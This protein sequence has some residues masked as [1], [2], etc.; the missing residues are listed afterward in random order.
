MIEG[1][2]NNAARTGHTPPTEPADQKR[3]D[4]LRVIVLATI[5]AVIGAYLIASSILI[6]KDGVFYI[7]QAQQVGHDLLGVAKRYPPAYPLSLFAAH[8]VARWFVGNDSTALWVLSSQITTLLLR[9]LALIVLFLAG[10]RLVGSRRSFHAVVIL[11]VLP[12]AAHDGSDVLREW[13]VLL[14]IAGGLWLLLW[15]VQQQRWH[16]FGWVGLLA[17]VGYSLHPTCVQLVLYGFLGL[18]LLGPRGAGGR[19]RLAGAGLVSALGFALAVAPLMVAT[20]QIAPQQ[21]Q[22]QASTTR[23]PVIV[24]VA[25]QPASNDPIQVNIDENQTAELAVEVLDPE[26]KGLKLE[27][28]L[29]PVGTRPV[30]SF[31]C[32]ANDACLLTISEREKNSVLVDGSKGVWAYEGIGCYAYPGAKD[33]PGLRPVY[34]LWSPVLGR[35]FYTA[36][37]PE[38]NLLLNSPSSGQWK[39]E[40]IAFYV[41]A[42]AK[43]SPQTVPIH[44]FQISK[45]EHFW[46]VE[47]LPPQH[48]KSEM[49]Y[50][51]IAWY[52]LSGH[53]LPT[54]ASFSE[55]I[56]RWRPS[57]EQAG[58][59]QL[60]LIA[61]GRQF[62]SCQLVEIHVRGTEDREQKAEGGEQRT[63]PSSVIRHPSS[64]AGLATAPVKAASGHRDGLALRSAEAINALIEGFA[65][66]LAFF[67]MLPLCIGFIHRWRHEATRQE[68]VL[69]G[70]LVVVNAALM[71]A[72]YVWI[73]PTSLRRYGMPMVAMTIFYIPVGFEL[74][75]RWL[76]G[77]C[78]RHLAPLWSWRPS[79]W[80]WL[81]AMTMV[82]VA[83]CIPKLVRPLG[84]GKEDYRQAAQWLRSNTPVGATVAVPDQR[85]AFYADRKGPVYEYQTDPRE[86]DYIVAIVPQDGSEGPLSHWDRAYVSP[87]DKSRAKRLVVYRRPGIQMVGP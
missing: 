22:Q 3:R 79:E 12:Y 67:F 57:H 65:E 58:T 70:G 16:A 1:E 24:S 5:S 71:F 61:G 11:C 9:T 69:I 55:G 25:G 34:R 29:V 43:R 37:R 18:V 14:V 62:D 35:H 46:S 48:I 53:P 82:G 54:G 73:E 74:M 45:Q 26:D 77:W 39:N 47:R 31:R 86:V 60:N 23:P 38:R 68:Q 19:L 87:A 40:G 84:D 80:F 4:L 20:G 33:A 42:E 32:P 52:G 76:A 41:P 63:A 50:D 21:L 51:G 27:A 72:R 2:F 30:Y 75:A 83:I 28:V 59:Y 17:G 15:A 13:P 85:I 7:G 56:L 10:R 49:A 36:D 66:N 78:N 81:Y 64:D 6:C 44:R 8:A